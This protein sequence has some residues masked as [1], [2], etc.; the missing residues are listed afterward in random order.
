MQLQSNPIHL[1][2]IHMNKIFLALLIAVTTQTFTTNTAFAATK[3]APAKPAAAKF[4]GVDYSGVYSC[5]GSNAKIGSYNL[6]VTFAMNKSHSRG[7][8]GRYDLSVVT[9][10]ATTYGGQASVNGSDMAI[11][12]EIVYGNA[13]IFSTGIARFK[14]IGK[15]RYSYTSQYY[16]SKQ[17]TNT[18][19]ANNTGNDGIESCVMQKEEVVPPVL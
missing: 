14:P 19:A 16:E 12:I 3:P 7:K 1:K 4:T 5:V 10:N 9:E 8:L 11:T 2:S 6:L 13:I 17:I 15:K 18:P